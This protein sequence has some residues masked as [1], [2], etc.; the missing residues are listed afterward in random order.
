[1][2]FSFR[3]V[4]SVA[5][6]TIQT[7][8]LTAA[9]KQK[10]GKCVHPE[11]GGI[12]SILALQA[13]TQTRTSLKFYLL[14]EVELI[15]TASETCSENLKR[16]HLHKEFSEN[17][18]HAVI[19]WSLHFY[20]LFLSWAEVF[21]CLCLLA[22][23]FFCVP[24]LKARFSSK[25]PFQHNWSTRGTSRSGR[26]VQG[27]GGRL[28][29][30]PFPSLEQHF[31]DSCSLPDTIYLYDPQSLIPRQ[32]LVCFSAPRWGGLSNFFLLFIMQRLLFQIPLERR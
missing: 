1:M 21:C 23:M 3:D 25:L 9:Q 24:F 11:P 17:S 6:S 29:F 13:Q 28:L 7:K 5:S 4:N 16:Q 22:R 27:R 31:C 19:N 18:V 15:I 32:A 20:Q 30:Q 2:S 12:C 8:V 10:E 26:V 14:F